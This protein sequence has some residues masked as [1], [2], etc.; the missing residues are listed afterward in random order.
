MRWLN[1]VI[2]KAGQG[3]SELYFTDEVLLLLREFDALNHIPS[4]K[5]SGITAKRLFLDFYH[6]AKKHQTMG[7]FQISL[8]ELFEQLGLPESYKT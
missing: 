5:K 2:Y 6:L 7:G 8:D 1:K 4:I 3:G